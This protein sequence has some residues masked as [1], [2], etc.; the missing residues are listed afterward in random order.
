[1]NG[2]LTDSIHREIVIK[3]WSDLPNHYTNC[4]LDQFVVMPNHVHGI[5]R[6][7]NNRIEDGHDHVETGLKP[8]STFKYSLSEIIRGF[9]TFTARRINE[10][11]NL[12]GRMFWQS[13]FYDHVIRNQNELNCIRRYIIDNPFNW[14]FDRNNEKNL[15]I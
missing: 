5:I 6:I 14:E 3:C 15:Y 10:Y 9:K 1:M 4:I 13:R 8:V 2:K 7:D 12:K 11:E